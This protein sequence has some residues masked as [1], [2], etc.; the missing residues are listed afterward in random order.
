MSEFIRSGGDAFGKAILD[1]YETGEEAM[2]TLY[3]VE[4]G[5][6]EEMP[7][8]DYFATFDDWTPTDRALTN[9]VHG[10]ILDIGA[11]AGRVSLHFQE[12]GHDV[13]AVDL[14]EGCLKV[15]EK[16]GVKNIR[17]HNILEGPLEGEKFD[18]ICL[19]GMN[20]GIP[21]LAKNRSQFIADLKSMLNPG[22]RI[23]GT[24]VNWDKTT[25]KIHIDFQRQLRDEGKHPVEMTLRFHYKGV[26]EDF[27]WVLTNSEEL[28]KLAEVHGLELESCIEISNATYGYVLL[29]NSQ[30]K[31]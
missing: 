28:E 26:E 12:K 14:S 19:F 2:T 16:R 22:G 3:R 31:T 25:K 29:N 15:L 6:E 20:L 23:I 5:N 27:S 17:R 4:D 8:S 13:V 7:A 18:T 1:C 9:W 30:G 11:G 21:G 24:Q 10:R